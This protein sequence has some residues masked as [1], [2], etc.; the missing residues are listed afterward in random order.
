[1]AILSGSRAGLW[2]FTAGLVTA[3][4]LMKSG[5]RS[6]RGKLALLLLTLALAAIFVFSCDFV[7]QRLAA[8]NGRNVG[9][10]AAIWRDALRIACKYPLC[11]IGPG[12]F[13]TASTIYKSFAGESTILFA[14]NEYVQALAEAG[15]LIGLLF[16]VLVFMALVEFA[17][18]DVHPLECPPSANTLKRG[19]QTLSASQEE[20]RCRPPPELMIGCLAALVAFLAHAV[21]EFVFQVTATALLATALFGYLSGMRARATQIADWRPASGPRILWNLACGLTLLALCGLQYVAWR[22]W[23][24]GLSSLSPQIAADEFAHALRLWPGNPERELAYAAMVRGQLS[25]VGTTQ[26]FAGNGLKLELERAIRLDP[27]NWQLRYQAFPLRAAESPSDARNEARRIVRL[28]PL[29]PALPLFFARYFAKRDREAAL[30]FMRVAAAF[31]ENLNP[32]LSLAWSLEPGA[33]LLWQVI[34]NTDAA[35][36]NLGNF[37]LTKG[38]PAM[39]VAAFERISIRVDPGTRA[40]NFL[41]AQNPDLALNLLPGQSLR[42]NYLR[43]RAYVLLGKFGEAIR[44]EEAVCNHAEAELAH[45]P[46]NSHLPPPEQAALASAETLFRA[47]ADE[48]DLQQLRRLADSS[49]LL[50][51]RWMVF[52]T[53]RDLGLFEAAART[54]LSLA[55]AVAEGRQQRD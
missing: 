20:N 9:F 51:I 1:M 11:G 48:R 3:V 25:R 26:E 41:N 7:L 29:Q 16:W 46:P 45:A 5:A 21:F 34:P 18:F 44:A 22:H 32:V 33:A 47:P 4:W 23:Q 8:E 40:E 52:Q 27:L 38:L 37:A 49:H 31:P 36:Q 53:E 10:K 14:E 30:E 39:A 42:E 6:R 13:A 55:R 35:L 54:G 2:A 17:A 12:S 50:Q 15:V 43:S 28:N 19:H 24:A